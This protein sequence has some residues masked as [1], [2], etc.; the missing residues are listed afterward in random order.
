MDIRDFGVQQPEYIQHPVS[1]VNVARQRSPDDFQPVAV[2]LQGQAAQLRQ[3]GDQVSR[4]VIR[5]PKHIGNVL[6]FAEQF[7]E[8]ILLL[9]QIEVPEML[10]GRSPSGLFR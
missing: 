4:P 7:H 6:P 10:H 8:D 1:P 5:C 2:H 3:I 9:V